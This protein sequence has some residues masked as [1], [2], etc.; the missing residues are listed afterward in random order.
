[1]G[2]TLD[3]RAATR[4][5]FRL[6]QAWD[7]AKRVYPELAKWKP[8]L[9]PDFKKYDDLITRYEKEKDQQEKLD[10]M[11][12]G[13]KAKDEAARKTTGDLMKAWQDAKSEYGDELDAIWPL[14]SSKDQADHLR[15]AT[16]F[17]N[18]LETY[19]KTRKTF[20]DQIDK[21]D[22]ALLKEAKNLSNQYKTK[23]NSI[24]AN[25]ARI[26]SETDQNDGRIR[27]GILAL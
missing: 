8:D 26:Q 27:A 23:F 24:K 10:D 25:I 20:W 9:M 1:M 13:Y 19:V 15:F 2:K 17:A 3:E 7:S 5:A 12:D 11:F 16:E 6:F 14:M 18:D 21:T 4:K 22:E